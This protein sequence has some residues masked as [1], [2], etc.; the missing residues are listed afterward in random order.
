MSIHNMLLLTN[1]NTSSLDILL[2]RAL[3]KLDFMDMSRL[4]YI[5]QT[6]PCF[7]T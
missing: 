3:S 1:N 7:M 6:V 4:V 5:W 2:S